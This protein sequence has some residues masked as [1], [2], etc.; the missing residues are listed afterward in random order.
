MNDAARK[1]MGPPEMYG[2]WEHARVTPEEKL[3]RAPGT[4][5]VAFLDGAGAKPSSRFPEDELT[6]QER[7]ILDCAD[8]IVFS[9]PRDYDIH[10]PPPPWSSSTPLPTAVA[11]RWRG[12]TRSGRGSARRLRRW[13]GRSSRGRVHGP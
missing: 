3:R 11:V 9:R 2:Q 5:L 8:G 12:S 1:D 4:V 7:E 6:P 10:R 13:W